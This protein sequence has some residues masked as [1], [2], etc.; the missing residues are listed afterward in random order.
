M[1][2]SS[3]PRPSSAP[4]TPS[5]A[6]SPNRETLR[7]LLAE[8]DAM[9]AEA[10]GGELA[11]SFPDSV[12]ERVES[13]EGFQRALLSQ[14]CDVVLVDDALGWI[15]VRGALSLVQETLPAAPL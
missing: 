10:I 15:D 11:H 8:D 13:R 7:V 5:R 3:V 9:A 6:R 2:S 14:R 12:V 1:F 4:G